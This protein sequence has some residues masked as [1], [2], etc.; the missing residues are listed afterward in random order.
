MLQKLYE[1]IDGKVLTADVR[2]SLQ[3]EFAAAVESKA[4]SIA[5]ARIE[6]IEAELQEQHQQHIKELDEACDEYRRKLEAEFS[7]R[8]AN[9]DDELER[10]KLMLNEKAQEYIDMRLREADRMIDLYAT[11]C[12]NEIAEVAQEAVVDRNTVLKVNAMYEALST[13]AAMAGHNIGMEINEVAKTENER[14]ND[15]ISALIDENHALQAENKALNNRLIFEQATGDVSMYQRERMRVGLAGMID[16]A[17]PDTLEANLKNLKE[18]YKTSSELD[19][20]KSSRRD[21]VG[22]LLFKNIN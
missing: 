18:S 16:D 7:E 9:S 19:F 22:D 5:E 8:A 11:R 20:A 15:R 3:R 4:G 13:F 6:E 12:A 10:H 1:K 17:E 2:E 21:D 14:Y